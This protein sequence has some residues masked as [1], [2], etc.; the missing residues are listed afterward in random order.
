ME[1]T[2]MCIKKLDSGSKK[3]KIQTLE[4]LSQT[5]DAR[6]LRHIIS[7]LD[8]SD[9]EVRGEAFSALVINENPITDFLITG[10][11]SAS[12]NIRAF[13]A[14]IL[15][16]RNEKKSSSKIIELTKDS[17]AMVRSCALGALGYLKAKNA[18]DAI[19]KCLYDT[20]L[21]VKK[22][23]LKAALDIGIRPDPEII[24]NLSHEKDK[25][26]NNLLSR[27]KWMDREGFEPSISP[28]PRAYPTSL[29]DRP[30]WSAFD[31]ISF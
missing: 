30:D 22:S 1:N 27:F 20:N 18:K 6:I 15:A 24:K 3:E 4:K 7:K 19:N 10:L 8:D 11:N 5:S 31:R 29:D 21:E 12:K 13:C 26:L 14:L 28:M 17:S 16:N 2:D 9:I 23:A 25:E